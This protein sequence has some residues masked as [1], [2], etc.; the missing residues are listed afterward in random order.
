MEWL[1]AAQ[2]W[3]ESELAPFSAEWDAKSHFPVDV[4]KA[5]AEQGF[6]GLY[7][8][9]ELGGMG[10]SRLETSIIFEA[11]RNCS[12]VPCVHKIK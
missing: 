5:A 11:L 10:L 4:I 9:P 7:T 1:N 6:M 8:D 3:G 12:I 2:K